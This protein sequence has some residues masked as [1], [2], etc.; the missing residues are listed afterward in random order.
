MTEA[1]SKVSVEFQTGNINAEEGSGKAYVFHSPCATSVRK[2][3]KETFISNAINDCPALGVKG[4]TITHSAR[5]NI[6]Q[7]IGG[8]VFQSTW[9][10]EDGEVFKL[11]AQGKV[12]GWNGRVRTA[13]LYVRL[14]ADGA[15]NRVHIQ[16]PSV[17]R[18]TLFETWTITGRYD[19]LTM[20]DAEA[21]GV[22]VLESCRAHGGEGPVSAMF[23][24]EEL[25]PEYR[26]PVKTVSK[27]VGSRVMI[28]EVHKR[29]LDL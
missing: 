9:S 24:I 27:R 15:M 22:L 16:V 26:S 6:Q 4:S 18:D 12:G 3:L 11:F 5:R 10:L 1:T 17:V 2:G 29:S 20:A 8:K 13:V 25:A 14:R 7:E 19:V 21:A 28:K 23:R